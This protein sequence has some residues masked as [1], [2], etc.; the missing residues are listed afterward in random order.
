[1]SKFRVEFGSEL[2]SVVDELAKRHGISRIDVLRS[3]LT[4]YKGASDS[5]SEQEYATSTHTQPTARLSRRAVE[6]E[7]FR[8]ATIVPGTKPPEESDV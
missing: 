6:E 3:A 8:T 2:T 1:M 4:L 7:G 5:A